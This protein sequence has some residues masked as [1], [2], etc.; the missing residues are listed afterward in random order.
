M[1]HFRVVLLLAVAVFI[2]PAFVS[3]QEG[4][5]GKPESRLSVPWEEFKNLI[6]LD[7]KQV[8]LTLETFKKLV[9]QT[10]TRT[11]PV[12]TLQGGIVTLTRA[13]FENLVGQMKPPASAEIPP[14]DHL[15][16]RAVYSGRMGKTSASFTAD[17]LVFVLKKD[18]FVKV[19]LLPQEAALEDIRIGQEQALVINENGFH[20]VLFRRPGEYRVSARFSAP[21]VEKGPQKLDFQ[22]IQT[23]V[24]L[25]DLLIPMKP[26]DVEIPQASSI[27]TRI[28]GSDT[29]VS[30]V[31]QTGTGL[32]VRW[33]KQMPVAEKLPARIYSETNHLV[34]IDDDALRVKTDIFLNILHNEISGIRLE[35]PGSINILTITG[36]GVGEWQESV[37]AGSRQITIPFTYGIKGSTLVQVSAEKPFTEG[38]AVEFSGLRVFGTVRETGTIGVELNTSAE[39]KVSEQTG[40]EKIPVARLPATL[41]ERS[42]KPMILGFKYLRHPY[43]L[44]LDVE[45]HEKIAVPMA[46]VHSASAVTLFTEDCKVVHRLIYQIRNS[47]KQFLEV[48]LPE[49]AD[50]WSVFVGNEPVESSINDRGMLLIPLIRSRTVNNNL[51]TFPLELIYCLTGSAFPSFGSRS[52]FLPAA[53]LLISQIVWSVYLPNDYAYLHFRSTLEKEEIIRGFP[54]LSGGKRVFDEKEAKSMPSASIQDRRQRLDRAY[55]GKDYQSQFRNVPLEEA[56][57]EQQVDN[58]MGF[59]GRLEDLAKQEI[60]LSPGGYATG[61][62][63]IQIKIPTGGQ[64]YRFAR[65]LV[66]TGDPL[67]M[68][69]IFVRQIWRKVFGWLVFIAVIGMLY[70]HRNRLARGWQQ[71]K[72]KWQA[73]FRIISGIRNPVL[74]MLGSGMLPMLLFGLFLILFLMKNRLAVPVLFFLWISLV[75]HGY[76]FFQKRGRRKSRSRRPKPKAE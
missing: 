40:L 60:P 56:Q 28:Q 22:I 45:K 25:L 27:E 37:L 75:Y 55:K 47:S 61:V 73:F 76:R 24:T 49:K 43:S 26:V 6:H 21:W 13:E 10:G 51:D 14:V 8:V 71:V 58:E 38:M 42:A 48:Q 29:R 34:S 54:L 68:E 20:Q 32:S 19:P 74:K 67:T 63:P 17:W 18:A 66:K 36:E 30:A 50:V 4:A 12:H 23:P 70:K 65:T 33:R 52:G 7:D 31:I 44:V 11:T 59:S 41:V 72:P 5:A 57:L 9:E 64:V 62:L 35:V 2:R 46:A 1:K 15:V 3:A 16:T 39:I 69:V 53:D